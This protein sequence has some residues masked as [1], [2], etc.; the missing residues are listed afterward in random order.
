MR[1]LLEGVEMRASAFSEYRMEANNP[2]P[3]LYQ[4]GYLTIKGYDKEFA[5]YTLAFPNEEVKYGFVDFITPFILQS[6]KMKTVFT[7]V[8]SF[9]NCVQEM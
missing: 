5:L 6:L 7:S 1:L 3:L 9:A 4:S 2:I 8:S